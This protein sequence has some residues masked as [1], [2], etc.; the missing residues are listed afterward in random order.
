M[1]IVV[2][3]AFTRFNFLDINLALFRFDCGSTSYLPGSSTPLDSGIITCRP[4]QDLP[5][6]KLNVEPAEHFACPSIRQEM[7]VTFRLDSCGCTQTTVSEI[8]ELFHVRQAVNK[9]FE[10]TITMLEIDDSTFSR[11][12]DAAYI[13]LLARDRK[14]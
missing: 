3:S 4:N 2:N 5:A 1:P 12:H 9:D 10:R 13:I 7:A 14:I 8:L 11:E 6:F